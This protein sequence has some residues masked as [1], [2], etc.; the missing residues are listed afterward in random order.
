MCLGGV[1]RYEKVLR[2]RMETMSKA[3]VRHRNVHPSLIEAFESVYFA[4]VPKSE[5]GL[6]V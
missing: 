5:S 6:S 3:K 2:Q 1:A 4:A